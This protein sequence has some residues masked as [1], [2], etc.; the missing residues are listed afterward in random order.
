MKKFLLSLTIV[1]TATMF[2]LPI[3]AKEPITLLLDGKELKGDA[4]PVII[5][6]TT[7]VPLRVIFEGLGAEVDWHAQTKTIKAVKGNRVITL[8]INQKQ[9]TVNKKI[10]NLSVPAQI[11]NGKTLV[12]GRFVAE[13][14]GAT[15][16]WDEMYR[17]VAIASNLTLVKKAVKQDINE[18]GKKDDIK[19]WAL[20]NLDYDGYK[21]YTLQVNE[22]KSNFTGDNV[23]TQFNIVDIKTGDGFKEI[24][25]SEYGPSA[26]ERTSF[27]RYDGK[28]IVLLG[29]IPGF[30]GDYHQYTG[31][32]SSDI[33]IDGSGV[34]KTLSLGNILHSWFYE[35]TFEL[36]NGKIVKVPK[37]LYKMNTVVTVLKPVTLKESRNNSKNGISLKPGEKVTIKE[38]DNKN[39]CSIVNSKGQVGW[40][41]IE[42]FYIIK[43][44]G[45]PAPEVFDGL[46]YFG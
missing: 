11:I 18:D 16:K 32:D 29:D 14:L 46:H 27:Y 31:K 22:A 19:L 5:K 38:T 43:S 20:Y 4:N 34:I 23:E 41:E 39:W 21:D 40:I 35:D 12:P 28:K 15:V 2:A 17:Q 8:K 13:S 24:A 42:E 44:L 37:E 10:V 1:L 25:V 36:K 33:K 6:G 26:D 7:L 45:L 3:N 9:A 30:Y